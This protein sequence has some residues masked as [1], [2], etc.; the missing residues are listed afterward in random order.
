MFSLPQKIAVLMQNFQ[1]DWFIA[2]GWAIDLYLGK[3]TRPHDD[4]EIAIFRRDQIALQNYLNGWLLQKAENAVL[5]TWNQ[6][7]FLELPVHAIH[8]FHETSEPQNFEV[9]LNESNA[10]E[11]IYRRNGRVTKSLTEIYLT[12][13]SGIKFLRPE[14]VLLYKSKNPRAKDEQDFESVVKRLDAE[15][16]K[17]FEDALA[18]CDSKHHW[19]Q[20][21]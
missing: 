10:D 20:K 2:G 19:L 5:S 6:N 17:W 1:S 11:W 15:S 16:K 21:L 12:T 9:L 18:I 8:C 14:I 4:I 13:N 7:E 3:I